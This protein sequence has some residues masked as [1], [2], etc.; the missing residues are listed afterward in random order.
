MKAVILA[1]GEGKR[2]KPFT[3]DM[4]KVMIPLANKPILEYVIEALSKN[5][6]HDIILVVG[7]KKERIMDYFGNGQ[8]YGVRIDYVIQERQI[9]TGHALLQAENY[10]DNDFLVLPGDNIID[11]KSVESI[12]QTK[13]HNALL[14]EKSITPSKYG[15]VQIKNDVIA[16]IIEKPVIADANQ[17]STGI[18]RFSLSIFDVLKEAMKEGKNNI[19]DAVQLLIK[20]GNKIYFS[21]NP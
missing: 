6:I 5:G 18:Y 21:I 15:V 19:T 12:A 2:L 11:K 8:K 3:E 10:L 13:G 14:I 1:A 7:F 16:G 9:G 17:V 4:P 20:R